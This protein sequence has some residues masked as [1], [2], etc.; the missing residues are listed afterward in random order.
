MARRKKITSKQ[1]KA[2]LDLLD[3]IENELPSNTSITISDEENEE[4]IDLFEGRGTQV[5][6]V[7]VIIDLALM[8]FQTQ[9]VLP[10]IKRGKYSLGAVFETWFG[11]ESVISDLAVDLE[12]TLSGYE[13]MIWNDDA[14]SALELI[15]EI[16]DRIN[17]VP[18]DA[19]I[20]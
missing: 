19:A 6:D 10:K 1:I 15:E 18:K 8:E 20:A 11:K 9:G 16:R 4:V 17:E 13:D 12:T 3:R 5:D 7:D 2:A 14:E